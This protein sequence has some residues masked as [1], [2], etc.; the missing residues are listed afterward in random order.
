M[1]EAT[2]KP[3]SDVVCLLFVGVTLVAMTLSM[4]IRHFGC[5]KITLSWI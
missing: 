4:K 3:A 5:S 1:D 2:S